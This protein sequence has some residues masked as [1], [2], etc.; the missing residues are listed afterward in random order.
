MPYAPKRPCVD[1]PCAGFATRTGRCLP[2]AQIYE[3][4]RRPSVAERYGPDWSAKRR[5]VLARDPLCRLCG[6]EPSVEVDHVL[7]RSAGGSNDEDNLQGLGRRCHAEKSTRERLARRRDATRGISN[8]LATPDSVHPADVP[9]QP[10]GPAHMSRSG[11][12][13]NSTRQ[14]RS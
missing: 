2:H 11:R 3:Q 4:T 1:Q 14:R 13:I 12:S 7:P 10:I 6:A 5:R 8:Y 9:A